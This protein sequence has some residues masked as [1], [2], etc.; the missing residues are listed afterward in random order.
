MSTFRRI[1]FS[2]IM[3]VGALAAR[4]QAPVG[5]KQVQVADTASNGRAMRVALWY[6]AQQG[7]ALAAPRMVA[8]NRVFEGV[9]VHADAPSETGIHPVV[10]MSHGTFGHSGNQAW[11]AH[12]LAQRG[13]VVA[14]PNHPG[15]SFFDKRPDQMKALWHRPADLS[16]VLDAL[17]ANPQWAGRVRPD[18]AAVAGHSLGGWT[19]LVL[20]GGRFDASQFASDCKRQAADYAPCTTFDELGVRQHPDHRRL[21]DAMPVDP[22]I[23]A[24]I[25]LDIG[26]AR[27]FTAGSLASLKT[28]VLLVAAGQPNP[29]LPEEKESR[30]LYEGMPRAGT[31]YARLAG[32]T[33]FTFIGLCTPRGASLLAQETPDESFVCKDGTGHN[34]VDLHRQVIQDVTRFLAKHLPAG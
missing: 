29:T 22:R 4:A 17:L 2:L 3:C 26:A 16:R 30:A 18:Q 12:A 7:A 11:L 28:P 32:A 25:L 33:H 8:G 21:L 6:P 24:A 31:E 27:G 20:A 34:R 14:A 19:A 23:R 10:L 13:Y 15:T 9:A 5:Y 1:V